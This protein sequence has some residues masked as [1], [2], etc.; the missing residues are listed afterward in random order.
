MGVSRVIDAVF[1]NSMIPIMMIAA[2]SL[3]V[4]SFPRLSLCTFARSALRVEVFFSCQWCFAPLFPQVFYGVCFMEPIL[5]APS[6]IDGEQ[7]SGLPP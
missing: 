2:M 6:N 4:F 7:V 5:F 1:R 3:D